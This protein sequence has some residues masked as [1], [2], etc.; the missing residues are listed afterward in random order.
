VLS[1][2]PVLIDTV[3]R[4][5]AGQPQVVAAV[6]WREL[7]M[8]VETNRCDVILLDVDHLG[9]GIAKR[10]VELVPH[11][12]RVVTLVAANRNDA[13]ALI[14]FLADHKVHRLLIK[15]APLGQTRLLLESA[16]TRCVQ[17]RQGAQAQQLSTSEQAVTPVRRVLARA[18][19]VGMRQTRAR[20]LLTALVL[21]AGL[22][23]LI[24]VL[25]PRS[26]ATP[27]QPL[28]S[29]LGATGVPRASSTARS[30]PSIAA[31]TVGL[32]A[33]GGTADRYAERL[34]GARQ[35]VAEGRLA[36]P[37]GDNALD[38]Y[39]GI[40]TVEPEHVAAREELRGVLEALFTQAEAALLGDSL[41]TAGTVLAHVRRAEA[42]SARLAFL[43]AQLERLALDADSAK[44]KVATGDAPTAEGAEG[45]VAGS[46][47]SNE[48]NSLLT[49][50]AARIERGQVLTPAGDSARDYI[51]RA[52]ALG[53]SD[54]RVVAMRAQV[55][56]TVVGSAQRVLTSGDFEQSARLS[57][58]ASDL[59]AEASSLR[60]LDA[61]ISAA[62]TER[63]ERR[64]AELLATGAER[65]AQGALLEPAEDSAF[66][67]LATL[68]EETPDYPGLDES[69]QTLMATFGVNGRAAI[70]A[71]EWPVAEAWL[72]ALT[73]A[74]ADS[75]RA[76][77]LRKEL[78]AARLQQQYLV[79]A[80]P[81]SELPLLEYTLPEYPT[82]ALREGIEGWVDVEF[83]IG[84]DGGPR[85]II[86][87]AAEPLGR[88]EE[89][90]LAAV[91][92]YRY[93]PFELDGRIYER[94][95][96]LRL[97]F[98]LERE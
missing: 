21:V 30:K 65:L 69:W 88:F 78:D 75:A 35:A 3:R 41:D 50:A 53:P 18:R 84:E 67:H 61:A 89:A 33:P 83:V 68:R 7:I 37:P 58:T 39:L 28:A 76:G 34:A 40:L 55:A 95:L 71:R 64:R 2:D 96:R 48:L 54:E 8:A 5:A 44:D 66:Y 73:R 16:V 46:P 27:E 57:R 25:T 6:H 93:R 97:R 60:A 59:G 38:Y 49:I 15:P 22:L 31:R 87:V 80:A 10:L 94:R 62:R 29:E 13:Q 1:S 79:S 11:A 45:V 70:A 26:P 74:E 9:L 4:A 51:T 77:E 47:V 85:E 52:A 86:A 19:T 98:T 90:A 32:A 14:G 82:T 12:T 36:E 63:E 92:N 42:D 72:D 24:Q 81:A 17:L 91:A 43:E 20:E 23:A 56:A